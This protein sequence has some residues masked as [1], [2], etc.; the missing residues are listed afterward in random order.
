MKAVIRDEDPS[1]RNVSQ[2]VSLPEGYQGGKEECR[3]PR[4]ARSEGGSA[5]G[6]RGSES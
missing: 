1:E 2:D 6:V 5:K 3:E 4:A